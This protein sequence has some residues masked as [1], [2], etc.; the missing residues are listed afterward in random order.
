MGRFS[1]C[2][3]L[4]VFQGVP[5]A[6]AWNRI[7]ATICSVPRGG[8]RKSAEHR[9]S[10]E[11]N[12]TAHEIQ[13]SAAGAP[14]SADLGA[15]E[16]ITS[17][18][19]G[20]TQ[21]QNRSQHLPAWKAALP[22]S[23]QSKGSRTLQKIR[24]GNV[25]IYLA[26]TAHVSN[27]SSAFVKELL[28]AVQPDCIFVELC[29]ARIPL[30]QNNAKNATLPANTSFRQ[31][32]QLQ[33]AQ[34]GS[35]LQALSTVLLTSIQEDYAKELGVELGGEFVCA[36]EY[37]KRHEHTHLV[38]GDRPVQLTLFRAWE[39]LRRW[40]KVK[41][42]IGLLWSF[43]RKPK[44]KEIQQWLDAVLKEESDILTQSFQELRK[45][46]PTLYTT[47]IS[48]RDA[49]LAAKLV[50]TCRVLSEHQ[51][52]TIV[53]IVGAGHVPGICLWLTQPVP[54][55]YKTPE[56]VLSDL[57]TTKR[58]AKHGVT[59]KEFIPAWIHD[60]PELPRSELDVR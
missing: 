19:N 16:N 23:V 44:Q 14:S 4:L 42:L 53:A 20:L 25:D 8:S 27:D 50:Q 60:V 59:T 22:L 56:R 13:P 58:W 21:Q 47:I 57:V 41:I 18:T 34:G 15:S 31:R 29:D 2:C 54:S 7:P 37:W 36:H 26:G 55:E 49:W 52:S 28:E 12:T 3:L 1:T 35:R 24:L 40:P 46:F 11:T 45:H 51:R 32:L 30:L 9:R 33:K 48:E 5:L 17:S 43:L 6:S 10:S 38:L 39:S